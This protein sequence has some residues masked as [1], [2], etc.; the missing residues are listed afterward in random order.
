MK[1]GDL[2]RSV[3]TQ[4]LVG[5]IIRQSRS[6]DGWLVQWNIGNRSYELDRHLEVLCK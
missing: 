6:D 4:D 1:I 2:V 5:I 3:H